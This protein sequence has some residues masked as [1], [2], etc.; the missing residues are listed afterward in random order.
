M[1]T[2]R[3]MFLIRAPADKVFEVLVDHT[4][5]PRWFKF[6]KEVTY[7]SKKVEVGAKSHWVTE[8]AGTKGELDVEYKE[9]IPGRMVRVENVGPFFRN[10]GGTFRLS[11][12]PNG[13]QVDFEI[14]YDIPIMIFGQILD[15]LVIS[16][17]LDREFDHGFQRM[18]EALEN[19]TLVES[20][21][22]LT[23]HFWRAIGA[24][25]NGISSGYVVLA[26]EDPESPAERLLL[27]ILHEVSRN[28]LAK[29]II[30]STDLPKPSFEETVAAPLNINLSEADF[31]DLTG[32]REDT[33]NQ[34]QVRNLTD[35]GLAL[36]AARQKIIDSKRV[37]LLLFTNLD[38]LIVR[39][40]GGQVS[41]FLHDTA[42]RV[43][44]IGSFECYVISRKICSEPVYVSLV[45]LSDA[46]LRFTPSTPN[47]LS[48][49][50]LDLVKCRGVRAANARLMLKA[51]NNLRYEWAESHGS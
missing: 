42:I 44:T 10:S 47:G 17:E 7:P 24:D 31:I 37:P 46:A 13:T 23:S 39:F 12:N 19:E 27:P 11:E 32:A 16:R 6:I 1:A 34:P 40:G 28:G 22:T 29:L 5:Y 50:I 2:L 20:R 45:S 15:R 4:R 9:L 36:S 8:I 43:R 49:A 21:R 35:I 38:P 30:A 26:A 51:N 14:Q 48:K 18:K 33:I 25:C 3:K 41:K